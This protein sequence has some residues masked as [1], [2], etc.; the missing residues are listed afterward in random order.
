MFSA[1][2]FAELTAAHV[3]S[4]AALAAR[5]ILLATVRDRCNL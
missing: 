4:V 5:G 1:T 3:R 2:A